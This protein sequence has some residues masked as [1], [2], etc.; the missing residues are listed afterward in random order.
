MLVCRENK[1]TVTLKL[2]KAQSLSFS[3]SLSHS[4]LFFF[5]STPT[6][7]SVPL[8]LS[9]TG[10]GQFPEPVFPFCFPV[11][12]SFTCICFCVPLCVPVRH[13]PVSDWLSANSL[14]CHNCLISQEQAFWKVTSCARC[15]LSQIATFSAWCS[16]IKKRVFRRCVNTLLIG[17]SAGTSQGLKK[18][19]SNCG[20]LT[21]KELIPIYFSM[22][23]HSVFLSQDKVEKICSHGFFVFTYTWLKPDLGF[24]RE[25]TDQ[26]MK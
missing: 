13:P 14:K 4:H 25:F 23:R 1:R 16:N 6:F 26:F 18:E 21:K 22:D 24:C 8:Y 5:H 17:S 11:H 7:F 10:T 15:S 12:V 2:H 3:V 20:R 19:F 9:Y